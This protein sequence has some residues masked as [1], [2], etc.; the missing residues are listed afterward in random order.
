MDNKMCAVYGI[1][2]N[3]QYMLIRLQ[4]LLLMRETRDDSK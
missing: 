3:K 4:P 1:A 2:I